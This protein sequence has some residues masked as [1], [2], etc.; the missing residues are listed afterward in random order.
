MKKRRT[1]LTFIILFLLLVAASLLG[2]VLGS[3]QLELSEVL[4]VLIGRG[5]RTAELI[6]FSLRLPRVGGAIL[7][8]AGLAVAGLLLQGVT[9][10]DLCAPN[11]IGVNSGAGLAVMVVLCLFPMAFRLLPL[12]AFA[13]AFGTTLIVL[14]VAYSAGGHS[15]K[16]TVVLA[17]VAVGTLLSAGISFLSQLYPDV[18]SSYTAFSVGGFSGVYA[19]DLPAPAA[20]ILIGILA[21]WCLAPRLNLLCLGDEIARS[22]GV[23]VRMLRL[24]TLMLASALCAAVVTFAGLLGFVGLIVPHMARRLLGHDLRL[25]IPAGALLG[26]VLVVLSDLAGRTLFS[27]AELP[28]G[29]LLAVLGA[30]FFLFLLFK[31][32]RAYD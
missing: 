2:L 15:S 14:G 6:L 27:P 18:L 5:E 28:A 22:L 3:A 9:D 1:V 10:N 13:G 17:G 7:A 19:E 24:V 26:A 23:R 11:I 29:I 30:P 4:K 32:R 20:I 21:A 12:A 31:R 16:T 8:G 25:L